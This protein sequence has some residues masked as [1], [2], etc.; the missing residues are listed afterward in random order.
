MLITYELDPP[1]EL[2]EGLFSL[3]K[4]KNGF[5]VFQSK[6]ETIPAD[7]RASVES[8][9]I[10]LNVYNER[11]KRVNQKRDR[12][13][14]AGVQNAVSAFDSDPK[15][16]QRI[17]GAVVLAMAETMLGMQSVLLEIATD[18]QKASISAAMGDFKT[19]W[20][21]A[22]GDIVNDISLPELLTI[23]K[24]LAANEKSKVFAAKAEKDLIAQQIFAQ[25]NA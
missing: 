19:D 16:T 6:I 7:A 2:P 20:I 10:G 13:I 18:E 5:S 8:D 23:G 25:F 11:R 24:S 14:N 17:I 22:N 21:D 12:A 9:V 1:D 4:N 3:G 15:S